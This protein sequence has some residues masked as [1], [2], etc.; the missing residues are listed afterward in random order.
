M[1]WICGNRRE[2]ENTKSDMMGILTH[3]KLGFLSKSPLPVR[4]GVRSCGGRKGAWLGVPV[5]V[6]GGRASSAT[7][8][9]ISSSRKKSVG[10]QDRVIFIEHSDTFPLRSFGLKAAPLQA[11]VFL[12]SDSD[13]PR[14]RQM[15]QGLPS[16]HERRT[17]F[18]LPQ[19]HLRDPTTSEL[20]SLHSMRS[21]LSPHSALSASG[22]APVSISASGHSRAFTLA[23]LKSL[24]HSSSVA[25]SPGEVSPA[26]SATGRQH[27]Q[28]P[29]RVVAP[30]PA[31]SATVTST[32]TTTTTTRSSV[33]T[34]TSVTDPV[35][36]EVSRVAHAVWTGGR[37]RES[38]VPEADLGTWG[39]EG[40]SSPSH[41]RILQNR[42]A[43]RDG[44]SHA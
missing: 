14:W 15:A 17:T 22:S 3:R 29:H 24:A 31:Q 5:C 41:L 6:Y 42:V 38:A 25:S 32:T 9:N 4:C 33:T 28:R 2:S 12:P 21:H 13:P 37:E 16:L 27:Q 30:P 11:P 7:G 1:T 44:A 18:G 19:I 36:G 10:V 23:S 8:S 40:W 26:L 43:G 35:T 39:E 34:H 20:G